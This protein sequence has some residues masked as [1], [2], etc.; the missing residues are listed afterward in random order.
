[1][2]QEDTT[3]KANDGGLGQKSYWRGKSLH[4]KVKGRRVCL[5]IVL[6]SSSK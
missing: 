2:Y 1:M 6:N 5:A 3:T 4:K